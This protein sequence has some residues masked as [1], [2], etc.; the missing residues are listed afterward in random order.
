MSG[1]ILEAQSHRTCAHQLNLT[2]L[3]PHRSV[4]NQRVSS[5]MQSNTSF[6][7]TVSKT[8]FAELCFQR[9]LYVLCI[10]CVKVK[11]KML[12]E[13]R[14]KLQETFWSWAGIQTRC[15]Q[16]VTSF[17]IYSSVNRMAPGSHS[18]GNLS[19]QRNYSANHWSPNWKKPTTNY[20]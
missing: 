9:T 20:G 6:K 2:I 4:F 16:R 5:T 18:I 10:L 12:I 8:K 1:S 11:G 19:N 7:Y 15:G 17:F 14:C 13:S 3:L